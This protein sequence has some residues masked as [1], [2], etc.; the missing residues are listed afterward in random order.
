MADSAA[1]AALKRSRDNV[2]TVIEAKTLEWTTAGCP[3]TF[4]VDGESYSWDSWLKTK[5][6][7]LKGLTEAVQALSSPWIARHTGRA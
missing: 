1:V 2:A 3:P 5:T 7:E 4:S 6:E